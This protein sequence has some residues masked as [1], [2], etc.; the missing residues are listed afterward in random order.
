MISIPVPFTPPLADQPLHD[1]NN[2]DSLEGEPS[3]RCRCAEPLTVVGPD[4]GPPNDHRPL[5]GVDHQPFHPGMEIRKGRIEFEVALNEGIAIGT[6]IRRNVIH[7]IRSV[8]FSQWIPVGSLPAVIHPAHGKS[9]QEF[10][11]SRS[12][13]GIQKESSSP[14]AGIGSASTGNTDA[15]TPRTL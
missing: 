3:I 1:P 11:C 14:R 2:L 12:N 10:G 9:A 6:A 13:A 8:Q 7:E 15:A 5:L 4:G